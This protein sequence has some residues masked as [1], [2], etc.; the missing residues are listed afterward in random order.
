[1]HNGIIGP[2]LFHMYSPF[3]KGNVDNCATM[4]HFARYQLNVYKAESYRVRAVY[5][6]IAE[7]FGEWSAIEFNAPYEL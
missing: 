5:F 3:R 6:V 2:A 1:M 4:M 7:K